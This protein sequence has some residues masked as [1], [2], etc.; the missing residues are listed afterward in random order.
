MSTCTPHATF[1]SPRALLAIGAIAIASLAIADEPQR[2][3]IDDQ[4]ALTPLQEFVG[5]WRGVGQLRRGSNEGSWIEESDWAWSF[6]DGG[7]ALAFH[8]PESKHF[9]EGTLLPGGEAGTFRLVCRTPGDEA[10]E[11]V[12]SGRL[13]DDGRLV[14]VAEAADDGDASLPARVTIRT[15]AGGDR[16]VVLLERKSGADRYLRLAEVGYTRKGSDFGKLATEIECI[17]TGG[18]GTIPV[19]YQGETYYVCCTGCRDLF[20]DDPETV[21]AEYRERLDEKR[22]AASGKRQTSRKR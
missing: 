2:S 9:A 19:T 1:T 11:A 20:N 15:V 21:L 3:R 4:E 12:Y 14:L 5:T 16:L 8:S 18:K 7:A 10:K 22:K 17:V 13:D 6:P